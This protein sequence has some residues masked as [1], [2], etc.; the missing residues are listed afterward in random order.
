MARS[1]RRAFA[2]E[3]VSTESFLNAWYLEQR[4]NAAWW[5]SSLDQYPSYSFTHGEAPD[6]LT[7]LV[8][9]KM[10]TNRKWKAI[11][12]LEWSCI[13]RRDKLLRNT[14]IHNRKDYLQKRRLY[15]HR[16]LSAAGF[17]FSIRIDWRMTNETLNLA[18][19]ALH[20]RIHE[21]IQLRIQ[22]RMRYVDR[23]NAKIFA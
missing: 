23:Q 8:G 20:K 1:P 13:S 6:H 3:T 9:M 22:Q 7:D 16:R 18:G 10:R 12:P 2:H 21:A 11:V 5:C 14:K 4:A 19:S 17:N 15:I